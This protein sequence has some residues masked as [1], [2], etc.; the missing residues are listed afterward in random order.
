MLQLKRDYETKR[1]ALRRNRRL[2]GGLLLVAAFLFLSMQLIE[3]PGFAVRLV[4]AATE[5][6]IVGGLADW[7]AVTALFRHPLGLPV[8]HTALT[9]PPQ[10][11]IG[12]SLAPF[13]RD[14]FLAPALP[15]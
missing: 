4:I 10:D 13:V 7:V 5:A 15:L 1:H 2:A 12:K 9:P 8:P 3:A 11:A 14:Q 6:A